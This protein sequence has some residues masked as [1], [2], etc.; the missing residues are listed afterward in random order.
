MRPSARQQ[1]ALIVAVQV[2]VMA[3]WFSASAV[4]PALRSEW[5]I[6]SAAAT[7]LTASVQLGFVTGAVAAATLNLPDRIS[8]QS[9]LTA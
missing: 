6:S 3:T 5:T 1:L 4:V 7:W 2:L 9:H 8:T